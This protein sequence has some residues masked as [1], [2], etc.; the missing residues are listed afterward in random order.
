[1]QEEQVTELLSQDTYRIEDV[2]PE[3]EIWLF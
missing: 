1:V 3:G 2:V